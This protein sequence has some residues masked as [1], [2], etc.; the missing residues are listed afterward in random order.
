[1]LGLA[2]K[3]NTHSTKNSPSLAL[4]THLT[5]WQLR[6]YDNESVYVADLTGPAVIGRQQSKDDVGLL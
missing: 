1:M 5:P 4:I 3:E 2:Y 6:V